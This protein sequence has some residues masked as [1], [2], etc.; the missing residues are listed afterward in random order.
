MG[1]AEES[2][3]ELGACVELVLDARLG[4]LV[5]LPASGREGFNQA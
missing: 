3:S 1:A 4:R 2:R 5:L